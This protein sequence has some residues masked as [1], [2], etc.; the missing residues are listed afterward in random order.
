MKFNIT[1]LLLFTSTAVATTT[2]TGTTDT[3]TTTISAE[4][5]C[6]SL[7][8][9]HIEPSELPEGVTLAD[10]RKCAEHSEAGSVESLEEGSLAPWS[11]VE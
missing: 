7:G 10:V 8:V 1:L 2:T 9:M 3:P 6:G 4:E 11:E 5:E